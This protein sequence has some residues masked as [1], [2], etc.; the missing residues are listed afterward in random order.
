M[1][2][3][4]QENVL[5]PIG[6]CFVARRYYNVR[7]NGTLGKVG[8]ETIA[9]AEQAREKHDF[10]RFT[11]FCLAKISFYAVFFLPLRQFFSG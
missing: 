7:A 10:S 8:N 6:E 9:N 2:C 4:I 3:S 5:F 11:G 1:F